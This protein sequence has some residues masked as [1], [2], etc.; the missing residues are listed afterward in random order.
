[1]IIAPSTENNRFRMAHSSTYFCCPCR[2]GLMVV[3]LWPNRLMRLPFSH[4][5]TCKIYSAREVSQHVCILII[6]ALLRTL[7]LPLQYKRKISCIIAF[8]TLITLI[9]AREECNFLQNI[10]PE[11]K[12]A[13]Y[14]ALAVAPRTRL[15]REENNALGGYTQ[16]GL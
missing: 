4:A 2:R 16:Y 10:Q 3:G 12:L 11:A 15:F 1:M 13:K 8:S 6:I 7:L 5:A 14:H 9:I